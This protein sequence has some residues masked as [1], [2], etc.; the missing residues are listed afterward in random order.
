MGSIMS[1]IRTAFAELDIDDYLRHCV[2]IFVDI[3]CMSKNEIEKMYGAV[4]AQ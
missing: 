4:A 3:S 1:D 2:Q